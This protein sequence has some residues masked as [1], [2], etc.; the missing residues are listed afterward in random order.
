[1]F[2]FAFFVCFLSFFV[3]FIFFACLFSNCLTWVMKLLFHFS[4]VLSFFHGD[5]FI[6][7][8]GKSSASSESEG[9][10]TSD[11]AEAESPEEVQ[12]GPGPRRT[13]RGLPSVKRTGGRKIG[14]T[15]IVRSTRKQTSKNGQP[16]RNRGKRVRGHQPTRSHEGIG[17]LER[18]ISWKE[19]G[20]EAPVTWNNETRWTTPQEKKDAYEFAGPGDPSTPYGTLQQKAP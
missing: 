10:D 8:T 5:F 15:N 18:E 11:T 17:V 20:A 7:Q 9:D 12:R 3:S 16:T 6:F 14:Q 13:P 2:L 4:C 1:M 19:G